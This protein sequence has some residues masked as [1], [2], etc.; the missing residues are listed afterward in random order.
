MSTASDKTIVAGWGE[1]DI[2]P[3]RTSELYGA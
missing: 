2:T 3:K 1:A